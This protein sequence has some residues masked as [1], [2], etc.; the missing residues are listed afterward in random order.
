MTK[1]LIFLTLPEVIR[2]QYRDAIASRHPDLD[3]TV[4]DN[5][6]DAR[7]AIE[8]AEIVLT[9]GAIMRDEVY[10]NAKSLKWIQ[11]LGTGVDGIVDMPSLG[12]DV[13][14]TSTRG[15]H[16]VPLS[17]MAFMQ[18]L[19][20]ARDFPRTVHCQDNGAWERWPAKL[21]YQK[22]VGILGVGMIAEELA[23]RL[24]A[25][26]MTVVGISRTSRELPGFDR[27]ADFLVDSVG[28]I[29][30]WHPDFD[31]FEIGL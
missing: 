2:N 7:D 25:F 17:E 29:F 21:L 22:T 16:G 23:P 15:I 27:F 20:L 26:G 24:K 5:R 19:G 31:A 18:M 9:F 14:V 10:E 11:A 3:I 8:D 6:D 28:E 13:I 1:L 30:L 4:V 12:K